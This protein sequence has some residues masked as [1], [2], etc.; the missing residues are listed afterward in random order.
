[1]AERARGD[2]GSTGGGV[3]DLLVVGG[4]INGAGIAR[5]AAGRG[6]SVLLSEADDLAS[7]TSSASTKLVH[8][9]LRYLEYY[10]LRLVRESLI[11]RERL[12]GVAP[13]IVW[14]LQFVLPQPPNGRPG[15]LIRLGL[16]LYDNLG[17]RKRLP[18]SFGVRFAGSPFGRGLKPGVRRGFVY[19]DCWIDDARMVALN[20]MDAADRGAAIRTRTRVAAVRA[21]KGVWTARLVDTVSGVETGVSARIVVNAAGARV[22]E[23]LAEATGARDTPQPRLVKGSHIVVPRLFEGPHAFILQNPD[24]RIVFAIP[25]EDRFTLVG[26]TDVPWTREQGPA[27]IDA[28]ETAYLCDS[29]NRYLARQIGPEDV[30]H[31]YSGV[32]PLFDDGREDASTVTRD[33]VLQVDEGAGG[34]PILSVFGGKITTYRRLAE[35]ALEKLEPWL[36]T[37]RGG[38]T[39]AV[40][41]P[42][43]DLPDGSLGDYTLAVQ[44]RW[45]F[46]GEALGARLARSYGTRTAAVVGDAASLADLGRHFGGGLHA[47]EVDY[48]VAHE[49]ART[50]EDILWRRSKLGLHLPPGAAAEI[51]AYLEGAR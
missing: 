35:H 20:C 43:G 41:L 44:R 34:A 14:P 10:E 48:L 46:L 8:G 28:A 12:L 40:P 29:V 47:R 11:E 21:D 26:T 18:R 31:S 33:Y 39:G 32:R 16:L 24:K 5:D 19:S 2:A 25:Y 4:G 27:R 7:H 17:G 22:G 13:H 38:W 9:G 51:D 3:Y 50:A 36:G 37:E 45:P 15:W 49:W 6:F 42:G 23:M 30:V 1:M